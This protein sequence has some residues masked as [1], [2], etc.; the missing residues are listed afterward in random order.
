LGLS[1]KAIFGSG[2]SQLR[3]GEKSYAETGLKA[4]V[5]TEPNMN[6][7]PRLLREAVL[8]LN[9]LFSNLGC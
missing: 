2:G 7:T 1:G 5:V 9:F 3:C 6:L 8:K 4:E